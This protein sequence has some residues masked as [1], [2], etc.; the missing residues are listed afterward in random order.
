[1]LK[2]SFLAG[3]LSISLRSKMSGP[4]RFLCDLG[5]LKKGHQNFPSSSKIRNSLPMVIIRKFCRKKCQKKLIEPGI[6][7]GFELIMSICSDQKRVRRATNSSEISCKIGTI[8]GQK[9]IFST[10]TGEYVPF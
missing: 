4:N 2:T 6:N 10:S 5:D 9:L 1:M 7:A 3:Y 8:T